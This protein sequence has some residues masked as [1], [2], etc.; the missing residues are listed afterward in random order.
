[1]FEFFKFRFNFKCTFA[2]LISMF[3][4]LSFQWKLFLGACGL[5][6]IKWGNF[7]NSE[8]DTNIL[9][10]ADDKSVVFNSFLN[11]KSILHIN[12]TSLWMDEIVIYFFFI[13]WVGMNLIS[14]ESGYFHKY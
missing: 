14:I 10:R 3:V 5:K 2:I 8:K 11:L 9:S 12:Q 13:I 7:K 1:M 6:Q 4:V